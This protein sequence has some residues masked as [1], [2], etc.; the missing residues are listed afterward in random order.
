MRILFCI[1][2]VL[3]FVVPARGDGEKDN[4]PDKVRRIPRD[5]IQVSAEREQ[6][7]RRQLQV[8]QGK[9]GALE[10]S[11]KS[12][13]AGLLP[14]V[15]IFERAVRCAL[16]Y[17]EFFS[18]RDLDKAARLLEEGIQRADELLAGK[19]GWPH[20]SGLVVRGY[21]SRLDNT[22]QPYGLVIP[23]NYDFGRSTPSR[24]DLWFHGRGETLSEVNFLWDR[25][26]NAGRYTPANTIVLHPYGRY[27]N[28]FKF[29]GEVDVIEALEDVQNRYRI[30]EERISVRGFSMGGAACWQF[31]VHYPDRWFA[32]NPGAG[33]SETPEF[34][35]FFQK[36][37]LDPTPWEK[38]LWNMYDCN[39]YAGNLAHLPTIAYS[40]EKD[41]QKQAADI[42]D[43][44]LRKRGI[45]LRHVIGP[46]MGHTIDD[47][48][49]KIIESAMNSLARH[50]RRVSADYI[51][52]ETSTL[53][54]NRM[55]WLT[56]D[57]LIEHWKPA[58]ISVEKVDG[59]VPFPSATR[60]YQVKTS[61]VSAFTLE[62]PAGTFS[63]VTKFGADAPQPL[64]IW[65]FGNEDFAK[66]RF[67]L[68]ASEAISGEGP[69]SDGS[70]RIQAHRAD[71]GTW[72]AGPVPAEGLR[73]VHNLQG[74]IDDAL[75]DS[76][77]FV[78][79]TGKA[80]HE[81]VEKWT[82]SEFERAVTHWRRHFRGDARLVR[83]TEVDENLIASS[84]LILWGDPQSNALIRRVL[85]E[86]PITWTDDRLRVGEKAYDSRHHAPVLIF[87]NPLNP[88]RY[89][90]LNSS[91][92]FRDYA[93][94]NNAR[95]VPMLPDWAVIDL[96]TPA[97]NVWPG[98]VVAADFFDEQ[99]EF[100]KSGE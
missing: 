99:W 10:R 24:C 37:T 100:K 80:A 9:I 56:V 7:L 40:G 2:A 98:R 22:V 33:F 21:I 18:P 54:Y 11:S 4:H 59:D 52:L 69:F 94:L 60:T 13:V 55:H 28:A 5:G 51:Q 12:M 36:E 64:M 3:L 25:M 75:M 82:T 90:V 49:K 42:M 63:T 73:K 23:D 26:N 19:P 45:R 48:S 89:V 86:L 97:G 93:Y 8:L 57:G 41:I 91:F 1:L 88:K 79:P 83:D 78:T 38:S 96:R 72:K 30:D 62:F 81:A 77:V 53:K 34:L 95:Q 58:K 85:P 87:P 70:A 35:K 39:R 16:D 31:A 20:R 84:N 66:E 14:D 44:A 43:V 65:V 27:S 67:V 61:N 29:A 32:A 47:G 68:K 71:D 6:S 74:P 17:H 50:G 46:N 15:M 92:T 76:F